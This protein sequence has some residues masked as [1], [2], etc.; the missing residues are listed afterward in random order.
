MG[1]GQRQAGNTLSGRRP[2]NYGKVGWLRR[3]KLLTG[4]RTAYQ[5]LVRL[6]MRL[7]RVDF[8]GTEDF[9]MVFARGERAEQLRA[10]IENGN[11]EVTDKATPVEPGTASDEDRGY[12]EMAA[13]SAYRL[14]RKQDKR[15]MRVDFDEAAE[16]MFLVYAR[17]VEAER[18]REALWAVGLVYRAEEPTT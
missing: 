2:L 13:R 8:R 1:R 6:D 3:F 9:L 12:L 4:A 7:L 11:V 16:P 14:M 5:M 10:L 18:L 15:L 17:G